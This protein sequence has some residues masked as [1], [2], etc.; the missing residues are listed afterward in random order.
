[1]GGILK[2]VKKNWKIWKVKNYLAKKFY[3]KKSF[4]LLCNSKEKSMIDKN[5]RIYTPK[6]FK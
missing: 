6:L 4:Y 2:C 5:V 1:M 3:P